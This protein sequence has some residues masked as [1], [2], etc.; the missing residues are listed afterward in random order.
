MLRTP[1]PAP[2]GATFS[3]TVR[4]RTPSS[5][6]IAAGTPEQIAAHLVGRGWRRGPGHSPHEFARLRDGQRGLVVL[7]RGSVLV[8]GQADVGH[9]ALAE[10]VQP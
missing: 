4:P 7:Y 10:L 3:P 5:Y 9:Q 2:S 1:P 6:T 8:Q